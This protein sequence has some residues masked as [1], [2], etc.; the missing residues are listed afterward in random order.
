MSGSLFIVRHAY[1]GQRKEWDGQDFL[2]PLP[3]KGMRQAEALVERFA[4]VE[5]AHLK[6]SPYVR[7]VQTMEPLAADRGLPVEPCDDLAEGTSAGRAIGLLESLVGRPTALCSH[8]DVI[9]AAVRELIT[10]G[11]RVDGRVDFA[12]GSIWELWGRAGSIESGRYI[13]PP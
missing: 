1:A 3:Q 13:D 9:E 11:M 2:R 4:G 10:R 8:G 6:S 12:K 5:L 7:C